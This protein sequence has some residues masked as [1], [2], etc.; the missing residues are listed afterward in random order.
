M[1]IKEPFGAVKDDIAVTCAVVF[2]NVGKV[3]ISG[4]S[5]IA[6]EHTEPVNPHAR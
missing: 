3:S 2:T 4:L 6:L 5:G 1:Q